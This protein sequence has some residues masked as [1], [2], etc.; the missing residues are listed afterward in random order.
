MTVVPVRTDK[1]VKEAPPTPGAEP[2]RTGGTGVGEFF[3]LNDGATLAWRWDP[4]TWRWI[5]WSMPVTNQPPPER[6]SELVRDALERVGEDRPLS[7]APK[8]DDEASP[9][10]TTATNQLYS[11]GI[12]K[13]RDNL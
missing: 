7:S 9:T 10:A 6:L 11:A 1:Q 12:Q 13:F 3:V 4:I 2:P 8:T 5:A